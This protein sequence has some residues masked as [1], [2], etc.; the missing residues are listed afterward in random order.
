MRA[1]FPDNLAV[2]TQ[3]EK[4]NNYEAP[5]YAIF[6]GFLTFNLC[7]THPVCYTPSICI[8]PL[9]KGKTTTLTCALWVTLLRFN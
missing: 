5:P 4:S 8:F 9:W 7:P 6:S 2:K 3:Y 1:T